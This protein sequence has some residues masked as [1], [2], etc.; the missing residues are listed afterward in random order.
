MIVLSYKKQPNTNKIIY[1]K[2]KIIYTQIKSNIILFVVNGTYNS[3]ISRFN[4]VKL[5]F[6]D[7]VAFCSSCQHF[8]LIQ[9][10]AYRNNFLGSF[11]Y[12]ILIEAENSFSYFCFLIN[13]CI[14][15]QKKKPP[16]SS[17]WYRDNCL[18][19]F[20]NTAKNLK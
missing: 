1:Y 6:T 10:R 3:W 16:F 2:L 18:Y 20:K 5:C 11:S 7:K 4:A 8:L 13:A 12:D 17:N 19:F 9:A 15:F 14:A